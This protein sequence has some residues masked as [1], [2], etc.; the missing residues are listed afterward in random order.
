MPWMVKNSRKKKELKAIAKVCEFAGEPTLVVDFSNK[1]PLMRVCLTKKDHATWFLQ[2]LEK[3]K[4]NDIEFKAGWSSKKLS[5]GYYISNWYSSDEVS[6]DEESVAAVL[7]WF[8]EEKQR[9][10]DH[11][12]SLISSFQSDVSSEK[13]KKA[14]SAKW[15]KRNDIIAQDTAGIKDAPA[16]FEKW[17]MK[18]VEQHYVRVLPFYGNK[19]S[20]GKCT[21]CH[22]TFPVIKGK[23]IKRCPC[24]K[25]PVQIVKTKNE[26]NGYTGSKEVILLQKV[27]D[28]L[29]QRHYVAERELVQGFEKYNIWYKGCY[30]MRADGTI[31]DYY[32]KWDWYNN[33]FYSDTSTYGWCNCQHLSLDAGVIY[34]FADLL[35]NT[36]YEY[37]ALDL[38]GECDPIHYLSRYK[39]MPQIEMLAKVGLTTLAKTIS[40]RNMTTD[41]KKPWEMLKVTKDG[42]N[43]MRNINANLTELSWFQYEAENNLLIDDEDIK[44]FS[45]RS[46]SAEN[47]S[48]IL[49]KMTAKK[50]RNYL[51]KQL[52]A[53]RLQSV[54]E[55]IYKWRDYMD[56]GTVMKMN[57]DLEMNYKPKNIV[58]A[59]DDA[60]N[61]TDIEKRSKEL[62][63]MFPGINDIFSSL[64]KYAYSDEKYSIVI[65]TDVKDIIREGKILKHCLDKTNIY[66]DRISRK[67]S[68][69]L[70]LRKNEDLDMPYYSL[71]V[72]PDG[73]TRQKRTTG[74][75][76][77]ADFQKECIP[78]IR[79]WQATLKRRLS[80]EDKALAET[81]AMLREAEFKDLQ[82]RKDEKD[83]TSMIRNGVLAGTYLIDALK[84]DLMLA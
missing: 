60:A 33:G 65:P 10:K 68:F 66:F 21:N 72:E 28:R 83:Y 58:V 80:K 35:S 19:E 27:E 47:L 74:D 61:V 67:E 70:F 7:N 77:E 15:K 52:E 2:S 3:K 76:Q 13:S 75:K 82:R 6:I 22:N 26:I 49:E 84:D 37:S 46:V 42:F 78:F 14:C 32:W 1:S 59:H 24:C 62:Q 69:I 31:K 5:F 63:E 34:P 79:K 20:E 30:V 4:Y 29:V 55:L 12:I 40:S 81:S 16:K 64:S 9:Y 51:E 18:Q 11:W 48:F 25:K 23:D 56:M 53:T 41:Y 8:G 57:M 71:E 44:W 17:G 43:R 39:V 36:E 38:V 45:E 73:T 50:V 54:N